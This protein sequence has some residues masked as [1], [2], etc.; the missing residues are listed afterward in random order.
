MLVNTVLSACMMSLGVGVTDMLS[1][2]TPKYV[3]ESVVAVLLLGR[4][5]A[6]TWI[7]FTTETFLASHV[8]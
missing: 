4:E 7:F 2:E 6:F 8:V 1:F 3:T 5:L